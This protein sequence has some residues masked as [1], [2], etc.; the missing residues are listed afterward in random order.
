MK[1]SKRQRKAHD[2]AS[3]FPLP[4]LLLA[5]AQASMAQIAEALAGAPSRLGVPSAELGVILTS[6]TLP[7]D[8]PPMVLA[9]DRTTVLAVAAALELRSQG[10][11]DDLTPVLILAQGRKMLCACGPDATLRPV[12]APGGVA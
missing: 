5:I 7:P 10:L 3:P 8:E 4:I 11:P 1:A 2:P 9:C 6:P 12:N